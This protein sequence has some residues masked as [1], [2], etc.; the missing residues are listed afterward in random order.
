MHVCVYIYIY[1]SI[2]YVMCMYIYIY[3]S[4]ICF[5]IVCRTNVSGWGSLEESNV[6]H[7]YSKAIRAIQSTVTTSRPAN[8]PQIYGK[9]HDIS[10][11]TKPTPQILAKT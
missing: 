11:W 4:N 5:Q 9:Y 3:T 6:Y 8:I 2:E 1:I 10:Q 7:K